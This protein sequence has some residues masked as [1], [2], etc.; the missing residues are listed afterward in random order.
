LGTVTG[1]VTAKAVNNCGNSYNTILSVAIVNGPLQQNSQPGFLA[2]SES[3]I[4]FPNPA[5]NIAHLSFTARDANKYMVTLTDINGKLLM[6]INGIGVKGE[7]IVNI[8]VHNYA[9]GIYII[10]L[11]N[12]R[13]E[14]K[15][16]K[17]LKG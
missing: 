2:M 12:Y 9:N 1:L 16:I 15:R 7:N 3:I 13:G 14:I 5:E 17:L 4:V 6:H 10:T 11:V 8:D